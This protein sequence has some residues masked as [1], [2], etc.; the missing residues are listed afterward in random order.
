VPFKCNLQRYTAVDHKG[1]GV[2]DGGSDNSSN[3]S[4]GSGGEMH[5]FTVATADYVATDGVD[6]SSGARLVRLRWGCTS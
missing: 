5:R 2:A 6:A 1:K 3:N 4:N